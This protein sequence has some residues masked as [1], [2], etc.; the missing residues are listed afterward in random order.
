MIVDFENSDHPADE[1]FD[2]CIVGAGAA[3][4]CLANELLASGR[5]VVVLEGGGLGRW[6]RRSHALNKTDSSGLQFDGAHVGRFRG[7]GGTTSAWAG[8][9]MEFE[10]IDFETRNWVPGSSWPISKADLLPFYKRAAVLEGIQHLAQDDDSVWRE[11][12]KQKPDLGDELEIGFS[13]FCPEP[14]FARLF[15]PIIQNPDLLLLIH[16]SAVGVNFSRERE[17]VLQSIAFRTLTGR[18]GSITAKAFVLCLG[19][20]E[21]SRFLLNQE[22]SRWNRSGLLGKYF[23]DHVRCHAA[24]VVSTNMA[25]H[26]WYFG[27]QPVAAK[28]IPKIKLSA[29]AQERYGLLHACG[30]IESHDNTFRTMRTAAQLLLGPTSNLTLRQLRDFVVDA[31][32]LLLQRFNARMSSEYVPYGRPFLIVNCEQPP[33]SN[34]SISLSTQR[35]KL[36][37]YRATIDWQISEQEIQTIRTYVGLATEYFERTGL[38]KIIA[39]ERLYTDKVTDITVDVFHHC[40]GTRMANSPDH[41]IVDPMLRLFGTSNAYV[42]STSVF[43]SSGFGNPTHTLLA[44]AVR[45]SD[46]LNAVLAS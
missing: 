1:V 29:A 19:G 34:S 7:I 3:G 13:R 16:A 28:Y 31:P 37:M 6:E 4:L 44:L 45:L 12:G 20:I 39:D 32:R 26:D 46:H 27:P 41:G 9:V 25:A 33:K 14:K 11:I 18:E 23:Q 8:Q 17:D 42:C 24:Q 30:M 2:V 36:G 43:P 38:A 35:D 21:S 10:K 5:K 15:A 22:H 40:G